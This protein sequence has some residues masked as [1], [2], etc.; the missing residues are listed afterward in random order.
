[1]GTIKAGTY[2]FNDILTPY[3]ENSATF[4]GNF[5][6]TIN[7]VPYNFKSIIISF[8]LMEY[9]I[10]GVI[11]DRT[12]YNFIL[13]EWLFTDARTHTWDNDVYVSNEAS[14]WYI[15]NT[16]YNEINGEEEDEITAYIEQKTWY[17]GVA[18]AIRTKKGTTAPI[19]SDNFASEI[20]SIPTG[21]TTPYFDGEI[22]IE[23]AQEGV[24]GLRRFKESVNSI[25][26]VETID[27]TS[28]TLNYGIAI[29]PIY[30]EDDDLTIQGFTCVYDYNSTQYTTI[31]LA[32]GSF[33]EIPFENLTFY[34][35]EFTVIES[36][37]TTVD[38]WLLANTEGVSV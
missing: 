7:G 14:E 13:N 11:G 3:P 31:I 10:T 20:L 37:N 21:E 23:K 30:I 28:L 36:S 25:T 29:E 16:N 38:E 9:S 12:I 26:A 22:I 15:A 19:L 18:N 17:E 4:Y 24:L 32:E 27:N 35:S 6:T 8:S 34:V 1:M 5:R 2:K 33:F